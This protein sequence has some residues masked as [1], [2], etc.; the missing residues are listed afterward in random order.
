MAE[1][2]HKTNIIVKKGHIYQEQ[3]ICLNVTVPVHTALII[4]KNLK[5]WLFS[6][7]AKCL[8][9]I[10]LQIQLQMTLQ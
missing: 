2:G 4:K 5:T 8:I 7:L 10:Q 3:A 1:K 9:N 6:A